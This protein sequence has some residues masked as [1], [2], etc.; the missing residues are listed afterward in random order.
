[1]C[2][3]I[4]ALAGTI[5]ASPTCPA[6]S[7]AVGSNTDNAI[8]IVDVS[9]GETIRSISTE[10][11]IIGLAADD[12][13]QLFY[14]AGITNLYSIPYGGG[15]S[16]LL[17]ASHSI[18]GLGYDSE[19]DTLFGV[20]GQRNRLVTIDL[21][22]FQMTSRTLNIYFDGFEVEAST[23]RLIGASDETLALVNIDATD[24]TFSHLAAYPDGLDD[25]DGLAV[26]DGH[27]YLVEGNS[28][29]AHVIDLSTGDRIDSFS[30]PFMSGGLAGATILRV[31]EPS[32][33]SQLSCFL[34]VLIFHNSHR[35]LRLAQ[36]PQ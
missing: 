32:T 34:A 35:K 28:R 36:V 14:Y 30:L 29:L 27:A 16:T 24:G 18:E 26:H 6:Q 9:S 22:T 19:S 31:P 25:A 4:W 5:I 20:T 11:G 8:Y 12:R 7:L 1:M 3:V 23:G 21:S 13:R 10:S 33:M 15:P 2:K 17:G